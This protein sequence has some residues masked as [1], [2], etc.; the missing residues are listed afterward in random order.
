V[1]CSLIPFCLI[2]MNQV[3]SNQRSSLS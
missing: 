1:A 2:F 3:P